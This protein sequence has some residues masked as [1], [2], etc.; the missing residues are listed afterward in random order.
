MPRRTGEHTSVPTKKTPNEQGVRFKGVSAEKAMTVTGAKAVLIS[1]AKARF[2]T[3]FSLNS[4]AKKSRVLL[5]SSC[6]LSLQAFPDH[7]RTNHF[8]TEQ[9]LFSEGTKTFRPRTET[10][11]EDELVAEGME[12]PAPVVASAQGVRATV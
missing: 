7:F 9:H 1:H 11:C 12:L 2:E 4:V 3:L 5:L 6:P 10:K 8:R